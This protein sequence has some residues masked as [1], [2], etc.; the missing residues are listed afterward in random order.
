MAHNLLGTRFLSTREPA[1]HG[2]GQSFTGP[3]TAVEA[4]T[5]SKASDVR[6][7]TR[8]MGYQG[9]DGSFTPIDD[10]AVIVRLP[11]P[12]DPNEVT[13]GTAGTGYT[14]LQNTE[15]ADALDACGLTAR[16]P[17][18]TCG[19]LGSGETLFICLDMGKDTVAGEDHTRYALI[20]D[21]RDGKSSLQ[22]L[23]TYTRVVCQNT[24][25]IALGKGDVKINLQH[26]GDLATDFRFSLDVI[27]QVEASSAHVKT[28]LETL[29]GLKVRA[30]ELTSVWD[31]TYPDPVK[32]SLVRQYEQVDDPTKF[33]PATLTRLQKMQERYAYDQG[34]RSSLRA[35]ATERYDVLCQDYPHLAGTGLGILNTV[36]EIAD[37]TRNGRDSA[38]SVVG[39]RA[40]EKVRCYRH[41]LTLA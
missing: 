4:I 15:I 13:L 17:V 21:K 22:L 29:H 11:L 33:D 31:A 16:W 8:R 19:V 7:E 40:D 24:L 35:A 5:D 26:G 1:W 2:I 30:E 12:E 10:R 36:A 18:E 14:L 6:I 3:K 27:D 20:T 39:F 32:G 25:N 28:A 34:L 9:M 23:T 37:H 38:A 41:L